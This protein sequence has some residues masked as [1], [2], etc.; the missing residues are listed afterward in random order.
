MA[1]WLHST[2]HKVRTA[3][4]SC[5]QERRAASEPAAQ[6]LHTP[7]T[8]YGLPKPAACSHRASEQ[9]A[10]TEPHP[11][12]QTAKD[13]PDCK[14]FPMYNEHGLGDGASYGGKAPRKLGWNGKFT[15][16]PTG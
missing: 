10:A 14:A 13:D 11:K 5:V 2:N 1:Q 15:T 3:K 8:K 12:T 16:V 7:T 4:A 6:W 9:R